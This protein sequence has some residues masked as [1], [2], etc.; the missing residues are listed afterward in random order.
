MNKNKNKKNVNRMIV[1]LL[2]VFGLLMASLTAQATYHSKGF[3]F[4]CS[5]ADEAGRL[6]TYKLGEG[7]QAALYPQTPRENPARIDLKVT[8]YDIDLLDQRMIFQSEDLVCQQ[9]GGILLTKRY[10]YSGVLLIE[11]RKGTDS[12]KES[13]RVYFRGEVIC[14]LTT[15][16]KIMAVCD[17]RQKL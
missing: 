7:L 4:E 5:A 12:L 13:D 15:K 17:P 14:T 1:N 6:A 10:N 16:R 2:V 9:S 11:P 8:D 3:T